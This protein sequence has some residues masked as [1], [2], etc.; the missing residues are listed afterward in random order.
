[1]SQERKAALAILTAVAET[2]RETSPTPA[3][4]LYAALMAKCSLAQFE[5]VIAQL[6]G[7]GLVVR[8][9]H[10]LTWVGPIFH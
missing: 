1:M 5:H 4:P 2:I 9:N 7:A 3:G 10:L 8:K 6:E